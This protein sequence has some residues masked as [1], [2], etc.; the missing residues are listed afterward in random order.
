MKMGKNDIIISKNQVRKAGENVRDDKATNEDYKTISLWRSKHI[1]IMTAMVNA[2]NRK[3]KKVNNLKAI[4]VARRLKRLSSIEFQLK[5]FPNMNL[6][7]CKILLGLGLFLKNYSKSKIFKSLWN[8]PIQ[9]RI[10]RL[11]LNLN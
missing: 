1:S 11:S 9:K 2:I 5:R 3:L 6:T 8:K 4:I 10:K 7:R